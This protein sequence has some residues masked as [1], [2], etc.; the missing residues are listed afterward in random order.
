LVWAW[1]FAAILALLWP[2]R[3]VGPLD[4]LPLDGVAEAMLLGVVFPSL[5][6]F[7]SR[8]L[9]TVVARGAIVA[10]L[11]L[12]AL[13]ALLLVPDGWC[14]QFVPGRPFVSD[15]AGIVPHSWDVRADWRTD[16][17]TCSAI[18]RR[19]YTGF[20]E[21]PVWFFNLPAA[22]GGWPADGDRPP[23]A[24]TT[25][26]VTGFIEAPR[27]GE[28]R[29]ELGPDMLETTTIRVDDNVVRDAV[30][31]DA[32]LHRILVESL[33]V[34]SGWRF[35]PR[36]N[37]ADLW[38]SRVM[39]T[40]KRPDRIDGM[41]RPIAG[42]LATTIVSMWMALWV[43]SFGTRIGAGMQSAPKGR[44]FARSAIVLGW[45]VAT[46]AAFAVLIATDRAD[47]ARWMVVALAGSALLPVPPRLRNLLGAFAL[48]GIPWLTLIA[49][50]GA[51]DVGRFWL[52]GVGHDYWQ[53]QRNAYRIVMQGYWLE[54][55]SPTF[56][57]QPLYRWIAGVLHLVFGDSS[58]GERFWDGACVLA[59]ALL[60][61][62]I[63]DAFAGFRAG[64]IA[65]ALT[66]TVFALGTPWTLIGQGLGEI[67]SAGFVCL[68]AHLALRSRRGS[69]GI[70]VAA[71]ILATLAFY[72]RLN[73]LPMAAAVALFALGPRLSVRG[74]ITTRPW[75]HRVAWRTAVAVPIVLVLGLL[76]FAWRTWHYTGVFSVFYGTQR[77]FLAIWQ[78]GVS[79]ATAFTRGLASAMVV[80]TVNDPAR[81][82]WRALPVLAGAA[83]A[84]LAVLGVPKLREL[85]AAPT[86]FILAAIAAAFV[87]RGSAY[88]GRFSVHVIG[89]AC[90][91]AVCAF[92]A[93]LGLP[94][95]CQNMR[96]SAVP[97]V[98]HTVT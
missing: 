39:A 41:L 63:A 34:E 56:W 21:F 19:P 31:L 92:A 1:G 55:G 64:L 93:L 40:L 71:G 53:F 43:A 11:A 98:K 85:P 16:P 42:W 17:P 3:I 15:A 82:D 18:M 88:P 81:F 12:K 49:S 29:I 36:W 77:Q 95:P 24:R 67:T 51:G 28:L 68:A 10:L 27:A 26:T 4:G 44:T 13:E 94:R 78:P 58:V 97:Q 54:G 86:L 32:G 61:W 48:I 33:L 46:S 23:T 47:A 73:N 96:L 72:A 66:L 9:T 62:R 50:A 35:V 65:A 60:A 22:S 30:S 70:A 25:M 84:V 7:H 91:L 20:G 87:A 37:G 5:L 83:A 45:S 76:L 38:S 57:F 79:A 2:A 69:A 89:V 6:W 59:T 74:I 90:A 80:L 75:R 8:F 52:Y 14:V